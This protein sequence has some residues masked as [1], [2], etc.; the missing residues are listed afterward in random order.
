MSTGKT[1]TISARS[2]ASDLD[3]FRLSRPVKNHLIKALDCLLVYK[4]RAA[5]IISKEQAEL[6]QEEIELI[7]IDDTPHELVFAKNDGSKGYRLSL[8]LQT[9]PVSAT[10]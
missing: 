9:D 7:I 3:R 4:T 8:K 1:L 5:H 2:F 6:I 10:G